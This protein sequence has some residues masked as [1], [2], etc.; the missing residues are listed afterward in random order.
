MTPNRGAFTKDEL[1]QKRVGVL[2]GGMSAERDVSLRTG[3]A[4]S[5]A[6]RG[7][8]YDVVEIDVGRDLPARLAAEK[9]DVAW[10]AVHG[11]YG[12]DGCLQGLLESLFIPYTGSGV[13]ASA[14][15]MD[16]VYA[17]Q[18]Y[19]AHG[20]PTP[21][22]RSFRDAASA[23]AAVDSLPFP[24]PVVVKPSREGSSVGVHICKTRDAYEAAVTDAAKYAGTL[25][26]E[27][28]V[29]GREV[30][31]GVLD[32]EAL[33]VIE[34]RAAREFYDY[35]AKYKAGT[36]TQYLFPAP[37]PPDQYARVNEVCLAAHQAL[38]CSGGSRSDVIVT[39]GGDVFLLETNTLPGMT[40]SSLLPKIAAGRGIDFP[41]LC[42]RL[43]LGACLKA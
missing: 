42:E 27:Q 4:V 12:E 20:I 35:D 11:R 1:K 18:V 39:D 24:F 34:V 15:G 28:F 26:V 36:G 37:L 25:L 40:A 23:L 14:L 22:Y 6:L 5:G 29:K 16:K 21:A 8:G 33:G 32:D 7:L 31:G 19:V 43:L 9:V 13:L 3:E 2:L 41:A 30:Q 10:L 17:K 38:G